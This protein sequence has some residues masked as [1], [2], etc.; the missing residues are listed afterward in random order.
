MFSAV[1]TILLGLL[2]EQNLLHRLAGEIGDLALEIAH[3]G[4]ARVAADELDQRVVRRPSTRSGAR[5]CLWTALGI[6]CLRAISSFSS[7]V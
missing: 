3:A 5:P 6:R 7:S 2:G 1:T 4:L